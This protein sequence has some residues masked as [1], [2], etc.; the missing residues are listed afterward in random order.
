MTRALITI[1]LLAGAV[2]CGAASAAPQKQPP[3][4]KSAAAVKAQENYSITCQ[5]CHGPAGKG[6]MPGSDL[7]SGTWK[8]GGT[9]PAI[10]KTISE[11]VPG[12]AMLPAKDRFTKAEIL[13]LAKLVRSFDKK[14]AGR[15]P[16]VKK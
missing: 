7:T 6:V 10:V 9:I 12:T 16:P 11:G 14:P 1:V 3:K 5:V 13:E 15:K 4:A 8:H 2:V